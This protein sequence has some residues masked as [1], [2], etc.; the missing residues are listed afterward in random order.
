MKPAL[1]RLI[2]GFTFWRVGISM[3]ISFS[4][5]K[6]GLTEALLGNIG[7]IVEH[8]SVVDREAFWIRG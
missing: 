4:L 6:T 3:S 1:N 7:I 5:T 2:S 8:L